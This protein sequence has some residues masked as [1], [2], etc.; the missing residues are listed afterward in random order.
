M[1]PLRLDGIVIDQHLFLDVLCLLIK[2][3]CIFYLCNFQADVWQYEELGVFFFLG[4]VL[5]ALLCELYAVMPF[6][7]GK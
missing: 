1:D 5:Q 3:C 7:D 6:I 2:R 4:D